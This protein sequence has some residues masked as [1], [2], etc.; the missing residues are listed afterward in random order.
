VSLLHGDESGDRI[1]TRTDREFLRES[2]LSP[3]VNRSPLYIYSNELSLSDS[4]DAIWGTKVYAVHNRENFGP[5]EAFRSQELR[6]YISQ[7]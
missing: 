2:L 5:A 7:R 4:R 3:A 6:D 1:W